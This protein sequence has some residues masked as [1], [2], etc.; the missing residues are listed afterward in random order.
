MLSA[1]QCCDS[2]RNSDSH[3]A[4]R[5]KLLC[6]RAR[7]LSLPTPRSF[8]SFEWWFECFL[9]LSSPCLPSQV[10]LCSSF[11]L[12]CKTY[13]VTGEKILCLLR[14]WRCI[15]ARRQQREGFTVQM[16]REDGETA[17]ECILPRRSCFGG[18]GRVP[19]L[20]CVIPV[21]GLGTNRWTQPD[22]CPFLQL[23][24]SCFP[25]KEGRSGSALSLL[26]FYLGCS[27]TCALSVSVQLPPAAQREGAGGNILDK[28]HHFLLPSW[29]HCFCL[30][31]PFH[32]D[33]GQTCTLLLPWD[34]V[35]DIVP[36]VDG[37]KG[38]P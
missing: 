7:A 6:R 31:H 15:S 35:A 28:S 24:H 11:L 20:C 3:V 37:R 2:R 14:E 23:R 9:P 29:L 27:D 10:P 18:Q 26:P 30:R 19:G 12:C 21:W 1:P 17:P 38:V 4:A 22:H 32:Q 33:N 36:Y 25:W 34:R 16:A 8:K 13:S 5:E